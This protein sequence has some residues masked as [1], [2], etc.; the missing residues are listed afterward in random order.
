MAQIES[1]RTIHITEG[2]PYRA[3]SFS[4]QLF[5]VTGMQKLV[6]FSR[7]HP[8]VKTIVYLKFLDIRIS[9][10]SLVDVAEVIHWIA[11]KQEP[12]L[13]P[14]ANDYLIDKVMRHLETAWEGYGKNA[15]PFPDNLRFG[16]AGSHDEKTWRAIWRR[17]TF[18]NHYQHKTVPSWRS[19]G[20]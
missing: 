7:T 17:M 3:R 18:L 8:G 10:Y 12:N 16:F 20:F 11:R 14:R 5:D 2:M 6:H 4:K 13:W 19:E 1:L 9:P 15:E